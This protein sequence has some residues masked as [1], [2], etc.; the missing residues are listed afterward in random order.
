MRAC[1][2]LQHLSTWKWFACLLIISFLF[3]CTPLHLPEATPTATLSPS[4]APSRLPPATLT[5][6]P[7]SAIQINDEQL[8]GV[9]IRFWHPYSGEIGALIEQLADEFSRQNPYGILVR[10]EAVSGVDVLDE[11]MEDALEEGDLP[12]LVIAPLYQALGWNQGRSIL[13][14]WSLYV[15]DSRWGISPSEQDRFEPNLW[16]AS[17]VDGQRWGIPARRVAQV[18]LYNA[19]W[20]RELGFAAAP[21]TLEEFQ[22]QACSVQAEQSQSGAESAKGYLFTHDYPTI[23][24]WLIAFEA[25][26]QAE[27]K[28]GYHFNSPQIQDALSYLHKLYDQGCTLGAGDLDPLEVFVQRRALFVPISSAQFASLPLAFE[29]VGNNDQW[30]VLPFPTLNGNGSVVL[31]GTDF[32]LLQSSAR[33]QLAAWLFVRWMLERENQRRLAT[34]SLGLPLHRDLNEELHNDLRLPLAYRVTLGTLPFATNEPMWGS[35]NTVRWAVSDASRQ[36]VAWYFTS[37]Q[38]P[39]LAQL[40]DKTANELHSGKP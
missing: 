2:Y 23:L 38:V 15:D 20:A 5:P 19:S 17:V 36:L 16:T 27:E 6:S 25:K 30:T 21:K 3:S 29:I 4:P 32:V 40:L 1:D 14:D 13:V 22:Q 18:L 39:S 35:W 28:N 8:Q 26:I 12:Q 10:S 7:T 37:D 11:R 34:E 31:Y 9:S 33:E 24:A